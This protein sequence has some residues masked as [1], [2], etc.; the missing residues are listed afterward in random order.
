MLNAAARKIACDERA[1]RVVTRVAIAFDASCNPFVMAKTT[2]NATATT[3]PAS[4]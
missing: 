2:A 1:A 4:I 3:S